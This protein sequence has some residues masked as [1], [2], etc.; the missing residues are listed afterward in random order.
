[1]TRVCR[2]KKCGR[3]LSSRNKALIQ[4]CDN[5]STDAKAKV[6]KIG[7]GILTL[8]TAV[9]LTAVKVASRKK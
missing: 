3:E 6:G 1:M 5:C 8:G 7:T 4:R 9:V 2:N